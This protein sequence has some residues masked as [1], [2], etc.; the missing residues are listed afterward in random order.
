M[1]HLNFL[2]SRQYLNVKSSN[3]K[4]LLNYQPIA[5][6]VNAPPCFVQYKSGVLKSWECDCT[7]TRPEDILVN[8]VMTLVGYSTNQDTWGCSG[9]WI[10]KNSWGPEW[11]ESGY[12]RLC[13]SIDPFD[14]IGTCNVLSFPHLPDVGLLPEVIPEEVTEVDS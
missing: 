2:E 8:H 12:M 4:Q 1:K 7:A 5:V 11:G 6:A 10:L 14:V 9:H 13:I 3:L